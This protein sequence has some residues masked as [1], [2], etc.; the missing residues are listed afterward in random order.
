MG[1]NKICTH[2]LIILGHQ[3]FLSEGSRITDED[4][5]M[6]GRTTTKKKLDIIL[7]PAKQCSLKEHFS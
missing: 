1:G 5:F 7:K 6:N 4:Y 3:G 2:S